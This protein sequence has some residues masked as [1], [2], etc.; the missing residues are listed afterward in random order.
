MK[1]TKHILSLI[2]TAG[3]LISFSSC[4]RDDDPI[5]S[6]PP[7]EGTSLELNGGEGGADAENTVFVDLSAANQEAVKRSSW[8]LAFF[9]GSNFRVRLNNTSG[10]SAIAVDASD[11]S[12]LSASDINLEDLAIQLGSPGA[13]ENIDD[14]TGDITKTLIPEI[15]EDASANKIYVVNPQGG[16]H[17]QTINADDLFKVRIS[18]VGQ[19]YQLEYA[20]LNDTDVKSASISKDSDYNYQFFSF[21]NGAIEVEPAKTAWD[22]R[23][24]WSLH[25]GAMP[26][27]ETYPY[28][29]S[30]LILINQLGGVEIAEVV[31]QDAEGAS[32]GNPD[33]DSFSADNISEVSFSSEEGAFASTWRKTTGTPLG[34]QYDRF[35]VIKD[36][37]GNV[38]KLK[39]ISMGVGE[40]AGT[41]GYPE[42]EYKLVQ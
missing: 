25:T 2:L 8:D 16:H 41:R 27:G 12:A 19:D 21:T 3:V 42:L 14:L 6:I 36:G 33:Y 17:G 34:A 20:P 31:F 37:D 32:N 7:S 30:D 5:P 26:T 1:T 4:S 9:N 13:F 24:T 11:L 35:Y 40:D 23:F 28:G 18:R 15:S 38:Y 29:Y 10:A 39:F 22:F